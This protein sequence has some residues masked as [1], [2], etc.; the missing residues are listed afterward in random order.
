MEGH[1]SLCWALAFWK[2]DLL[3]AND[4]QDLFCLPYTY[5]PRINNQLKEFASAWNSHPLPTEGG[6]SPLQV[7]RSGLLSSSADCQKEILAGPT[8][9]YGYVRHRHVTC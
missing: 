9:K 4:D 8:V 5:L 3:D 1:L 7:R 6:L 2:T